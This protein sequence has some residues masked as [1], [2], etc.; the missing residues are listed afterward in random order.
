[1]ICGICKETEAIEFSMCQVCKDKFDSA[2]DQMVKNQK[3]VHKLIKERLETATPEELLL[4]MSPTE[5]KQ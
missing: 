5:T 2:L 4:F 3:A 1:M